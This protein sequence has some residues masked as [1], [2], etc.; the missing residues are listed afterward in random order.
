M[1]GKRSVEHGDFV[2]K[3]ALYRRDIIAVDTD[4]PLSLVPIL[5]TLSSGYGHQV[6][7]NDINQYGRN[8]QIDLS[9]ITGVS[10]TLQVWML[11][12][13]GDDALID[14]GSSSSSSS[15]SGSG[16]ALDL[17][18]ATA[19]WVKVAEKSISGPELWVVKDVP[20]GKFKIIASVHGGG[21]SDPVHIVE[22]H[23]A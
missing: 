13:V 5:N 8:A 16:S 11:V 19:A 10:V 18:I 20:P 2:T 3:P 14:L 22:Q 17:P 23:A 12:E 6:E 21:G 1:P 7:N 4:G 15:S 9:V